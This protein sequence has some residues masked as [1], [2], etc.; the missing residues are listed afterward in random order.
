M[1]MT[2]AQQKALKNLYCRYIGDLG[3]KVIV[4]G[5]PLTSY[6]AFRRKAKPVHHL[7]LFAIP[8][9]GMH[10]AIEKDGYTHS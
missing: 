7:E 4:K 5:D 10:I 6:L 9:W 1:T 3:I 8:L 2:K